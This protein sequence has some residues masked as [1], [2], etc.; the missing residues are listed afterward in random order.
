MRVNEVLYLITIVPMP[1][2]GEKDNDALLLMQAEPSH[3]KHCK[4]PTEK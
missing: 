4:H 2:L 3:P 1:T